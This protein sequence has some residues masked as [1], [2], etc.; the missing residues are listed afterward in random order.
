M[1]QRLCKIPSLLSQTNR[2]KQQ[3]LLH[4]EPSGQPDGQ[5][6]A[7]VRQALLKQ[8]CSQLTPPLL[9]EAQ[10]HQHMQELIQSGSAGISSVLALTLSVTLQYKTESV[11]LCCI[12]MH[13]DTGYSPIA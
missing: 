4:A 11:I 8:A 12:T 9:K 5:A 7:S 10:G 1:H 13:I 6:L 3:G 2:S